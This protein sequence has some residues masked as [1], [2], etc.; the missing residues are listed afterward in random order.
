MRQ[1]GWF[2]Y[3]SEDLTRIDPAMARIT[4]I[5]VFGTGWDYDGRVDGIALTVHST[6]HG[7]VDGASN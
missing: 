3:T 5:A 1:N 6:S 2:E 7:H 4:N